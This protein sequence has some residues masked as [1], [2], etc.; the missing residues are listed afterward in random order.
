MNFKH[1]K[2]KCKI[3]NL[4]TAHLTISFAK[5]Y[6]EKD[7]LLSNHSCQFRGLFVTFCDQACMHGRPI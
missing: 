5:K 1:T 4:L 3:V 6:V 7:D 2:T